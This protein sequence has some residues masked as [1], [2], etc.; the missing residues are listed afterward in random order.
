MPD[1]RE[2]R[3]LEFDTDDLDCAGECAPIETDP[4]PVSL[5]EGAVVRSGH[6]RVS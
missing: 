1:D 6:A 5:E 3:A 2:M 4:N